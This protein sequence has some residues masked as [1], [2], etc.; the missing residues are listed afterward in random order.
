[1]AMNAPDLAEVIAAWP[2]LPDEAKRRIL[3]MVE[4]SIPP[5]STEGR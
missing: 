3:V 4:A 2:N 1:M 5:S